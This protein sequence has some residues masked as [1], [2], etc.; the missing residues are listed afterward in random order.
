MGE[1]NSLIFG[2]VMLLLI[3]VY[4]LINTILKKDEYYLQIVRLNKFYKFYVINRKLTIYENVSSLSQ[5]RKLEPDAIIYFA[6]KNNRQGIKNIVENILMNRKNYSA[7]SNEF[8]NI[9]DG[10]Y[11]NKYKFNIFNK[12]IRWIKII[13]CKSI[14]LKPTLDFIVSYQVSYTSPAG[15]NHYERKAKY[16]YDNLVR[17]CSDYESQKN[18]EELRKNFIEMERAKMTDSLRYN[19]LKRDGFKCRI[20]GATSDDG[21]KLHVDH[22]IPVSKGGRTIISNLQTLC[23]RCNI[24]KSNKM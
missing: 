7:Y 16:N 4:I 23:E 3:F 18:Q 11:V 15:R 8:K 24:G 14:K 12:F 9:I 19:V 13:N 6:I 21:I 2:L 20:C 17:L 10:I 5:L 22:I 1:Q